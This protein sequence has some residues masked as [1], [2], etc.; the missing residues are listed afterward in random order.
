M[1]TPL[2]RIHINATILR[3]GREVNTPKGVETPAP[4]LQVHRPG[5]PGAGLAA[6]IEKW[7]PEH[8][9]DPR[10]KLKI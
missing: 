9:Y 8:A 2:I 5:K 10:A 1:P 6:F 4:I 3:G 7:A